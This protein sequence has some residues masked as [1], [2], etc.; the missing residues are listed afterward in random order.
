[1][2]LKHKELELASVYMDGETFEFE[3]NYPNNNILFIGELLYSKITEEFKV[4]FAINMEKLTAYD[5]HG[6]E[7]D[8]INSKVLKVIEEQIVNTIK[9]DLYKTLN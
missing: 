5:Q 6:K 1:M 3:Y 7:I 9:E 8:C 2:R 4:D